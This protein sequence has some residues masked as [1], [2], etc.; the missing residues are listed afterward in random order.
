M[1]DNP[2]TRLLALGQSVWLDFIERKLLVEGGLARLIGDDGLRG[3]TSNPTIFAKAIGAGDAYD[4]DIRRFDANADATQIAEGLMV[5][6]VRRA[7]DLFRPVYDGCDGQDGLVSI[8]VRPSL[9]L[10]TQGTIDEARRLWRACDRPNVM[11]KIPGTQPGLAAIETCLAEGIN[12]N[13]TLLFSVDR[14]R[15]VMAAHCSALERR[16]AAGEDVAR[17]ASVASFFVSRVDTNVDAKIDARLKAGASGGEA[18][19]LTALKSKIAIA[20]AKLA[21]VAFEEMRAGERWRKLA[22]RGA[23]VQRPLWASTSTKNPALPDV[24]YVE[25]LIAP[26]TVDTLP[27]ETIDAYRDHGNATVRIHE[28][29]DQ[30]LAQIRMLGELGID[31]ATVTRELETEG[32][33]KFADSFDELIRTVAAKRARVRAA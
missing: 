8:E 26:D 2:L 17:I 14:Y 16:L 13:I 3:M 11:V 15:E 20:N 23:R 7:A 12:I 6:D 27:P 24:Y 10:D 18:E 30:A 33:K 21:Y 9:A 19:K 32:V 4:D 28:G 25:A 5:A 29:L 31:L 22:Q 1:K